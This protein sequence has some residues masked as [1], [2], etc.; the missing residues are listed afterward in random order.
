M[1][2]NP[3]MARRA[4]WD[5]YWA[6]G[7]L[8]SCV[9][10][11]AANY[12]GAIGGFWAGVFAPLAPGQAVLDLATGNGALPLMVSQ[13]F[14]GRAGP[15][16]TAVDLAQV[17]PGWYRAD[18][19]PGVNFHSGVAMEQLPFADASY[20]L[21]V[22]QYGFEYA[23]R[24]PA[25]AECLRVLK[26]AGELAMV[27]HHADSVLARVGR[28]ELAHHA[29]LD[30]PGGLLAAARAV[31]P[32]F[33]RARAGADLRAV[34]AA[35]AAREQYNAAIRSLAAEIAS[36]PAPDL[37]REARDAIHNV[38][39][40][41]GTDPAPAMARL[42]GYAAALSAAALRSAEMVEH[43]LDAGQAAGLVER[44]RGLRPGARV[45]CEPLAQKE[46]ILGWALRL[47]PP[48]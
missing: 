20:D 12:T 45:S 38:L 48:G 34:P 31:L 22:S 19:H 11:F 4:A 18:E 47:L 13:Q 32:W 39:A 33:A 25:L 27:L 29:F 44:L 37:L 41:V 2:A 10:S 3:D 17:C 8:H 7:T 40:S 43:A 14:S 15:A 46:G 21:V 36:R 42:D 23:R 28:S 35:L 1:Q 26:P 30:A 16:V 24:E 5:A 6:A 9:G